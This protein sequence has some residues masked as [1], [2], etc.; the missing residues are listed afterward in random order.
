MSMSHAFAASTWGIVVPLHTHDSASHPD[1]LLCELEEL[2]HYEDVEEEVKLPASTLQEQTAALMLCFPEGSRTP[3]SELLIRLALSADVEDMM[4]AIVTTLQTDPNVVLHL[5]S[6]VYF[7]ALQLDCDVLCRTEGQRVALF[8]CLHRLLDGGA[9]VHPA[10]YATTP[11]VG[12]P[13]SC[14]HHSWCGPDDSMFDP[15]VA[16]ESECSHYLLYPK[17]RRLRT[18]HDVVF[19]SVQAVKLAVHHHAVVMAI[20]DAVLRRARDDQGV[21]FRIPQLYVSPQHAFTNQRLFAEA[22]HRREVYSMAMEESRVV[23]SLLDCIGLMRVRVNAITHQRIRD[24]CSYEVGVDGVEVVKTLSW[25]TNPHMLP[26]VQWQIDAFA[27]HP[28]AGATALDLKHAA[29]EFARSHHASSFF[30]YLLS[31]TVV[32]SPEQ[33]APTDVYLLQSSKR[34]VQ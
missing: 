26:L 3:T 25:C 29:A 10:L 28:W 14:M 21:I 8:T 17:F 16:F 2:L 22:V 13:A 15:L 18:L 6:G 23:L 12:N 20:R 7:I 19:A 31:L 1:G 24:V 11:Y 5:V 30:E 33:E 9:P 32:G 34:V 4:H 27:E